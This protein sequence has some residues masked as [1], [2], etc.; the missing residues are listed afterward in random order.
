V[1][2]RENCVFLDGINFNISVVVISVM[3][4]IIHQPCAAAYDLA[5]CR[6]VIELYYLY[7]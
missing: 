3:R 2:F 6:A 4:S 1:K 5:D 7:M